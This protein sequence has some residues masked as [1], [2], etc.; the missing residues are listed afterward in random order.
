MYFIFG[1][2]ANL[3]VVFDELAV[4][5]DTNELL[6]LLGR[7]YL[8]A[9]V[10]SA[11]LSNRLCLAHGLGSSVFI[12]IIDFLLTQHM[13]THQFQGLLSLT[14][15]RLIIFRSLISI[16]NLLIFICSQDVVDVQEDEGPRYHLSWQIANVLRGLV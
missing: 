14:Q 16:A 2:K 5:Y 4:G 9:Y 8:I 7:I 3:L 6:A 15:Q 12:F 11:Y 13:L 1:I 10:H